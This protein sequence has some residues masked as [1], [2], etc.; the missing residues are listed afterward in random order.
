VLKIKGEVLSEVYL[1]RVGDEIRLMVDR[2]GNKAC[3]LTLENGAV[4][5][6]EIGAEFG[7]QRDLFGQVVVIREEDDDLDDFDDDDEC[8]DDCDCLDDLDDDDDPDDTDE[9]ADPA[10][11]SKT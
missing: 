9:Y 6:D 4:S 8:D 1:D 10:K 7:F 3:L 5:L 2:G 11:A